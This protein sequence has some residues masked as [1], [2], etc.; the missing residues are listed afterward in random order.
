ML[1]GAAFVTTLVGASGCCPELRSAVQKE[2]VDALPEDGSGLRS[3]TFKAPDCFDSKK[4]TVF[5]TL[6]KSGK[7]KATVKLND[8]EV[9]EIPEQTCD[10]VN[11]AV[12]AL[13]DAVGGAIKDTI[14]DP[15]CLIHI[16]PQQDFS[17]DDQVIIQAQ[18]K[19]ELEWQVIKLPKDSIQVGD[20]KL[21]IAIADSAQQCTGEDKRQKSRLGY[22]VVS[23]VDSSCDEKF[24]K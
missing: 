16:G 21:D 4:D 23:D 18:R 14:G 10:L 13:G 9:V 20:N 8:L 19:E 15:A 12:K 6:W 24:K 11:Q 1:A 22:T 17:H 3:Y 7:Q 5:A 2:A